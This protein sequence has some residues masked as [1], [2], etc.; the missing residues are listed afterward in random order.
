MIDNYREAIDVVMADEEVNRRYHMQ[1][2]DLGG[3]PYAD[4]LS[5]NGLNGPTG[6]PRF[7]HTM[8]EKKRTVK[9]A[10]DIIIQEKKITLA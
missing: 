7:E 9:S 1:P 3:R 5:D 2:V 10:G 6:T 4:V 8:T